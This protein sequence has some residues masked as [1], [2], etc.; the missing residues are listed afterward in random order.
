M[1]QSSEQV[2]Y[3]H[4]QIAIQPSNSSDIHKSGSSSTHGGSSS[5][6]GRHCSIASHVELG[7]GVGPGLFVRA[8]AAG[9]HQKV[10]DSADHHRP[11]LRNTRSQIGGRGRPPPLVV[12]AKVSSRPR[13]G[14]RA[15]S[16]GEGERRRRSRGFHCVC[17]RSLGRIPQRKL[18]SA[19]IFAP[20]IDLTMDVPHSLCAPPR[21]CDP[22]NLCLKNADE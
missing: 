22:E 17:S 8:A 14:P 15:Q 21:P 18:G 5:M 19:C 3:R 2:L 4:H 7:N 20:A 1:N 13:G 16:G 6:V 12:A 9:Q 10:D 11:V